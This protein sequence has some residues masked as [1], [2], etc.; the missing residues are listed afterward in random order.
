MKQRNNGVFMDAVDKQIL[1]KLESDSRVS[2]LS[3]A[4]ELG[5]SEGTIRQRVSKMLKKGIIKRFTVDLGSHTTAI[6]EITT[7]SKVPTQKISEKIQKL[8]VK[9]IFEVAGRNS[10]IA[11]IHASDLGKLNSIVESIRSIDGV[12]Q[13]ETFPVLRE[14]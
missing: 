1:E 9:K 6:V 7:L 11:V 5:V 12:T 10:I 4:K 2:F 8:G 14:Y 3:V 13:T